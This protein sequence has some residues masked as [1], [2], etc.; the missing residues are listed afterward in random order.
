MTELHAMPALRAALRR[1][2]VFA[3]AG[4]LF[5][6]AATAGPWPEGSSLPLLPLENASLQERVAQLGPRLQESFQFVA[7]GD[8]RAL[9]DGEWQ[10][11]SRRRN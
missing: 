7:F 2:L 10:A 3:V 4:A 9:A 11:S 5:A 8:Q 1:S 6:T